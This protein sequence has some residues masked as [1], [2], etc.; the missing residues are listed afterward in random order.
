MEIMENNNQSVMHLLN[1]GSE[2]A[3]LNQKITDFT[4]VISGQ[5]HM[6]DELVKRDE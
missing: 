4:Q 2:I 1:I 5:S 6:L 3:K